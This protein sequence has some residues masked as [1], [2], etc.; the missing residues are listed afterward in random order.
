MD[1]DYWPQGICVASL[2]VAFCL[3]LGEAEAGSAGKQPAEEYPSLASKRRR[4]GG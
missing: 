4:G 3:A 1:P 2:V